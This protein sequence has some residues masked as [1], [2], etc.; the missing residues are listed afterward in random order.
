MQTFYSSCSS[1][2]PDL[3]ESIAESDRARMQPGSPALYMGYNRA[4]AEDCGLTS[5]HANG[6]T[7]DLQGR[8]TIPGER[9]T[10]AAMPTKLRPWSWKRFL[11]LQPG[12]CGCFLC[13]SN[14]Q[15]RLRPF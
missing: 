12:E 13:V 6:M 1:I 4:G 3:V 5:S 9:S 8:L 2:S 14:R 7:F 15:H 11:H 10:T